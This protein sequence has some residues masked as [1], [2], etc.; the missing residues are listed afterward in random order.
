ME[1]AEHEKSGEGGAGNE[2]EGEGR[3][4]EG[5]RAPLADSLVWPR[6]VEVVSVLVEKAL[7]MALAQYEDVVE[8]LAA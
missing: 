4:V 1:T 2:R 6:R 3:R 7:E 8:A 5:G